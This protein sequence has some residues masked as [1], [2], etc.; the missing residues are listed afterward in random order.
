MRNGAFELKAIWNGAKKTWAYL[1]AIPSKFLETLLTL[2][3]IPW[4]SERS[5]R[6]FVRKQKFLL[7][8]VS[9]NL[10]YLVF[11][12]LS[13]WTITAHWND[14]QT[15]QLVTAFLSLMLLATQ[16]IESVFKSYKALKSP[17]SVDEC[18]LVDNPSDL[19]KV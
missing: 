2:T 11:M 8:A 3:G 17:S 6:W 16:Y 1:R 5:S 4:L 13:G 12:G 15:L 10:L 14:L 7:A 18:A 9:A 19:P